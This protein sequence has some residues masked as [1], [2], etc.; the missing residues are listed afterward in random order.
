MT[1][2]IVGVSKVSVL[3][4]Y[5]DQ[6]H[7]LVFNGIAWELHFPTNLEN[8]L[9]ILPIMNTCQ[10]ERERERERAMIS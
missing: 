2:K 9:D 7:D 1:W 8:I 4:I 3:Y 6:Y 10:W 5:I